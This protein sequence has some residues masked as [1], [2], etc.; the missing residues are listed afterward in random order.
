[1]HWD[2]TK[3]VRAGSLLACYSR[4]PVPMLAIGCKVLIVTMHLNFQC[5][6]QCERIRGDA[7]Q[8]AMSGA[9]LCATHQLHSSRDGGTGV[10]AHEPYWW[11]LGLN[12][13]S[14]VQQIDLGVTVSAQ[15]QHHSNCVK[16][17]LDVL[18]S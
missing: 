3:I 10:D 18:D 2:Q 11:Q 7:A 9:R 6:G 14:A 8:H 1:M 13:N 16:I 5:V 17:M 12:P 15:L 4:R